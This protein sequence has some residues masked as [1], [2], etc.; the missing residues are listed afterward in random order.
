MLEKQIIKL[1]PKARLKGN[2]NTRIKKGKYESK[3][4]K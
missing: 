2:K 1:S 4:R 3:F